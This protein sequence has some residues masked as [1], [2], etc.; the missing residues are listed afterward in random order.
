[1]A[2]PIDVKQICLDLSNA[3]LVLFDLVES[4]GDAAP[5]EDYND[6]A[7]LRLVVDK[8]EA[9]RSYYYHRNL[10]RMLA[11]GLSPETL[12]KMVKED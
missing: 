1:M 6:M 8:S 5:L 2:E 3:A 12:L 10:Q 11:L 7:I 9:I 4:K